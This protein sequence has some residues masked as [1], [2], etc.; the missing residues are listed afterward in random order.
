M[1]RLEKLINELC[2]GGVEFKSLE[3]LFIIK[4]GY[5]PS[6]SNSEFWDNGTIPWFRME[7]IRANGHILND[8]IQHITPE[9]VKGKLFPKD[10]IIMATTATIGEHALITVDSLANQRF[11]VFTKQNSEQKNLNMKYVYYYFDIID[12]W[13]K[14]NTKV[15]S[16][17]AVDLQKLKKYMMPVPPLE[18]QCEIIKILDNFTELTAEL[19][20]RKKQYE[21][22]RDKLLTLD[23]SIPM[24]ALKD[25]ATSMYRGSGIKKDQVT[26]EGIPC[27]RYGEI[28]SIYNTSFQ[29]CI[30]HTKL[31]F[32]SSPKY[33]EYGNVLFAITGENVEDIAKSIAYLGNEKC[34]AGGDIVVMKHSQN[35]RYL[36]HVLNT[37]MA[38]EQK[39]KGKVKSKVVHS[40][41]PSLEQIKIPLPSLDIQ[42]RFANI[43][44]NFEAICTDLNI[45]LPAE[46]EARQKQ[47]E[48]YR[49][50]LLTYVQ[51]GHNILT[52]RQTDRI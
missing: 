35:P 36:A 13:C 15:S 34:L 31:E 16:F 2:P 4:N 19:T 8:S 28:Y 20:A 26:D 27:V 30:S 10:S 7:D 5:T 52:D 12:E 42:E 40:N 23:Y 11:T 43:L 33:F 39:S 1:S 9:A 24:V 51:T 29:K 6:K 38:K 46:V 17:P 41:I 3:E 44:D 50:Q 49:N 45:G 25:I 22:Y 14:K 37:A 48:F 32:V 21:Y 18:I 47:Y